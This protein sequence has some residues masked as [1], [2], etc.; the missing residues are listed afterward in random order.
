MLCSR[1]EC[2]F[3]RAGDRV[4]CRLHAWHGVL[5]LSY[6]TSTCPNSHPFLFPLPS[7]IPFLPPIFLSF[8]FSLTP[9][10]SLIV[11]H[12]IEDHHNISNCAYSMHGSTFPSF[13]CLLFSSPPFFPPLLPSPP[14][15]FLL[16]PLCP[17][18]SLFSLLFFSSSPSLRTLPQ[19]VWVVSMKGL[20]EP[21]LIVYTIVL[22]RDHWII[23]WQLLTES[24]RVATVWDPLETQRK[25]SC[26]N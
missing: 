16:F 7:L 19:V 5:P 4:Q 1:F 14:L 8:F 23:L 12:I 2:L 3:F 6:D 11:L 26:R 17:S 15:P 10:S 18:L 13:W 25:L 9:S 20:E 24:P 22:D 21:S